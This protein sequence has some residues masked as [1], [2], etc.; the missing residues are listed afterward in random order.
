MKNY[1]EE[2]RKIVNNLKQKGIRATHID[3]ITEYSQY[4]LSQQIRNNSVSEEH[5]H[6]IKKFYDDF[7]KNPEKFK[8]IHREAKAFFAGEHHEQK[9]ISQDEQPNAL[10]SR[11]SIDKLLQ[12]HTTILESI[13]LQHE[14]TNNVLKFLSES[15][16]T[17]VK[18]LLLNSKDMLARATGLFLKGE[19][20]STIAL[21]S[22]ARLEKKPEASLVYEADKMFAALSEKSLQQSSVA[23]EHM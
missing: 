4:Y 23:G 10:P 3:Y 20:V 8:N 22:L 18:T 15:I 1:T 13:R 11:D 9:I 12:S 21:Q 17:D 2:A 16:A 14:T 7:L 6:A 19:A 5:Y